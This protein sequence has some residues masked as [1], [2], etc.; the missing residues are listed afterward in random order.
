MMVYETL[1]PLPE[2]LESF[3]SNNNQKKF[4]KNANS[5]GILTNIV[6]TLL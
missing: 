6:Q 5:F 1:L 3:P 4:N 2:Q